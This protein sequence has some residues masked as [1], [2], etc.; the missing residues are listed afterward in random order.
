MEVFCRA[1][2]NPSSE[3]GKRVAQLQAYQ[4]KRRSMTNWAW[5]EAAKM[6]MQSL[7]EICNSDSE[8]LLTELLLSSYT[9]IWG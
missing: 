5:R 7:E 4:G 3:N 6:L 1:L 9:I 8:I 2:I